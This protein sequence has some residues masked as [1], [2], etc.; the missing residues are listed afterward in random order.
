MAK[1][2][3]ATIQ[4]NEAFRVITIDGM[5]WIC[6]YTGTTI[7]APFDFAT[8][9]VEYL[10]K[11]QPWKVNSQLK[12]MKVLLGLRWFYHLKNIIQD[13][14][15]LRLFLA[16]GRWLNPYTGQWIQGIHRDG[17]TVIPK[18]IQD[19]ASALVMT[20]IESNREFL[21]LDRLQDIMNQAQRNKAAAAFHDSADAQAALEYRRSSYH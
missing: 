16:D 8:S 18:T 5:Q 10:I 3:R 9:A 19:I 14:P 13:E 6:P 21:S 15:R 20:K 1:K 11:N 4:E 17:E 7:D 2:I 12:P